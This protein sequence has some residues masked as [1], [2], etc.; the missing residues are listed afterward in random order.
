[1][2]YSRY[3]VLSAFLF[4][5]GRKTVSLHTVMTFLLERSSWEGSQVQK[6]RQS[7]VISWTT[8]CCCNFLLVFLFIYLSHVYRSFTNKE[9]HMQFSFHI[10]RL[11]DSDVKQIWFIH[12]L[13]ITFMMQRIQYWIFNSERYGS[14]WS[15]FFEIHDEKGENNQKTLSSSALYWWY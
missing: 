14:I 2:H 8:Y 15:E 12:S 9:I 1:M 5:W 3:N 10:F 11:Q 4:L 6:G 7:N 13:F